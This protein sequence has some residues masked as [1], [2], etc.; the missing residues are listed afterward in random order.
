MPRPPSADLEARAVAVEVLLAVLR[1]RENL[2]NALDTRLGALADGRDRGLAREL[3]YGVL[4]WLPRLR[5]FLARLLDQPLRA[6]DTDI[7]CILVLGIYQMAYTRVP[8]YAAVDSA[9]ALAVKRRK[10]WAKG[11]INAVLRRYQRERE[12]LEAETA[13][14]GPA[15]HAHPAWLAA[16]LQQAWPDHWPAVLAANNARAP[17]TLRVNTRRHSRADYLARLQAAGIAAVPGR[18][19]PHAVILGAAMDVHAVP[20]FDAGDVSVQ[21]E[22]AQL[23]APLLAPQPGERILD[24]CAAPGGKTAHLL[25]A[26]PGLDELVAVEQDASRTTL[27]RDTL[28][29]LGLACTVHTAD[30]AASDTWWDGRPF[31][32]IL[33]DAPCSATGVIRR[34]PDIK[35][36]RDADQLDAFA[37]TQARLLEALWPTLAAGGTLLYATCSTL[38]PENGTIMDAF[39]AT[40]RDARADPLPEDW[41]HPHGPGRQI[42]PGDGDMDGFYYARL[43]KL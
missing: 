19:S 7:E 3:S 26:C 18:H 41:G 27:L 14:D 4:R 11:L 36:R 32:R 8:P 6:R 39:L 23:A 5:H 21:D 20:G 43:R 15:G 33:L 34:H 12:A 31:Q 35:I 1:G 13:S 17:M 40:H 28:D 29:R 30:A 2:N 10:P 24:A 22:A 37:A 38:P 25:E 16:A 9:V 42:L